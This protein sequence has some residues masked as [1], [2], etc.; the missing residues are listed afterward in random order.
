MPNLQ[1]EIGAGAPGRMVCG[2]DEVGRGPLAGPVVAGAVWLDI[3]AIPSLI[4][5]KADDSKRLSRKARA[6]MCDTLTAPGSRWIA[7]AIGIADVAEV[8]RL[9]ILRA[10]HLAMRRAVAALAPRPAHALVDGHLDPGLDIPSAPVVGGDRISLSIACASIIAKVHRDRI[11][12]DLAI[13]HPA[14][15]WDRNSGYG[16]AEHLAAL[17]GHGPTRHHRRS[18]SPVAACC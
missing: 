7:W 2:V 12:A 13:A 5:G 11:M 3:G 4:T 15:G 17:R 14:Y 1:L 8:D 6:R 18:F 16:T 10:S 9:N